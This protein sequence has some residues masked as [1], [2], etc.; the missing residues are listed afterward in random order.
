MC[1]KQTKK[2]NSSETTTNYSKLN[3]TWRERGRGNIDVFDSPSPPTRYKL[4]GYARLRA[5]NIRV[6]LS[7]ISFTSLNK[8]VCGVELREQNTRK[9]GHLYTTH[10]HDLRMSFAAHTETHL[11][12]TTPLIRCPDNSGRWACISTSLPHGSGRRSCV[13]ILHTPARFYAKR[14]N[15]S[16]WLRYAHD[17]RFIMDMHTYTLFSFIHVTSTLSAALQSK[18]VFVWCGSTWHVHN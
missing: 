6:T 8:V 14:D 5:C 2:V 7:L 11:L 10:T 1:A 12:S 13:Q 15:L 18:R 4:R 16:T 3:I 17:A 9:E